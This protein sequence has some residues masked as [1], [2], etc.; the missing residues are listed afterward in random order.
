MLIKPKM[1]TIIALFAS[2]S[3]PA[4]DKIFVKAKKRSFDKLTTQLAATSKAPPRRSLVN[5]AGPDGE[6]SADTTS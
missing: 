2:S 3:S 6:R 1:L 4:R 5:P